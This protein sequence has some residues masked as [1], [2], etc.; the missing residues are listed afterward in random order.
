M[1]LFQIFKTLQNKFKIKIKFFNKY[2]IYN[3]INWFI[4]IF[5]YIFIVILINFINLNILL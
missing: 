2:G 5:Y 3:I 1:K 4:K